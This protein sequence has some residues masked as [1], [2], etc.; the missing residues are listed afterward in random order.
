[1]LA[2]ERRASLLKEVTSTGYIEVAEMS[3]RFGVSEP[4]IRRDLDQLHEQ[5]KLIRTRGGAI[6]ATRSTT[7]VV[8]YE[9]KRH[10]QTEQKQRIAIEAA[11]L[12]QAGD[13]IIL[14][15]GSTTFELAQQLLQAR[16]LTVVTNDLRIAV[17]LAGNPNIG[18]IS[19]GG[20]ARAAVYSLVGPET[21]RFL[22]NIHVN[23]TFLAV[24]AVHPNGGVYNNIPEE[25]GVK[26]AMIQ[27]AEKVVLVADSTKF[28]SRGFAHVCDLEQLDVLITDDGISEMVMRRL[29]ESDV[30]VRIV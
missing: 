21:V 30:D 15:A 26:K 8:P 16:Q 25:T 18:L 24:D 9:I 1:M 28:T 19:S 10:A 3:T 17:Q 11:R 22:E 12:V 2:E 7:L 23:T 20:I 4:T 6:S 5:G 29:S 13:R 14:D 27:A